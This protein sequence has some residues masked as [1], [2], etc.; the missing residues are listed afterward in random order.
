MSGH[1]KWS[2]VKHQKATTDVVKGMAFTKAARAITL[3]VRE[4]GGVGDPD[5][6]FHLRL[7][8][9][10]ARDVNMPKENIERAVEKGK[11]AGGEAIE[12]IFYEGYGPFGVA[13]IV[14]V[15]TDNKQRTV[16]VI[17]NLLDRSGGTLASPGAVSYLFKQCAVCTIL[18]SSISFDTLLE[19]VVEAGADDVVE[20]ADMYEV[21][22]AISKNPGVKQ[23][24]SEQGITVDNT[25]IIMKPISS[26]VLPAPKMQKID[27]LIEDLESLDD[28]QKVF[29]NGV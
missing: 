23:R 26:I 5:R 13:C 25:E 17:K 20:T 21:Y 3:A 10:K 16:S 9:E 29:M 15:A 14:E 22:S 24:L 28:V 11:G 27:M 1:S 18:K 7:A 12:Q 8:I 2:K 4:G 19:V 6:N